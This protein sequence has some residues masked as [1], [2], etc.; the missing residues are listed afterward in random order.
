MKNVRNTTDR[1]RADRQRCHSKSS[2]ASSPSVRPDH[3][4]EPSQIASPSTAYRPPKVDRHESAHAKVTT[5][6]AIYMQRLCKPS[7]LRAKGATIR[8]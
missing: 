5:T 7:P 6:L 8:F 2:R 4:C 3:R 1:G